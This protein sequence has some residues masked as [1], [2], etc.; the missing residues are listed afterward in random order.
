MREVE[1]GYTFHNSKV[2]GIMDANFFT[3]TVLERGLLPFA[4]YHYNGNY[5]F[6]QG[7]GEPKL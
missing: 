1:N 5:N 6:M 2:N 7:N 4:Q 3:N